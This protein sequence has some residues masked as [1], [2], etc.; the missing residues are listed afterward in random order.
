MTKSKALDVFG[1]F[2]MS[3]TVEASDTPEKWW[4]M[5]KVC[6]RLHCPMAEKCQH[7]D[8][9]KCAHE[10]KFLYSAVGMILDDIEGVGDLMSSL[11]KSIY[12]VMLVPVARQIFFYMKKDYGMTESEMFYTTRKDDIRAH[13]VS[14]ELRR[15]LTLYASLLDKFKINELWKKK[16]HQSPTVESVGGIYFDGD[17]T[18]GDPFHHQK[19]SRPQR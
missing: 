18:K 4:G 14:E 1:S 12:S 13:P 6:D 3:D 19:I 17:D 15:S 8:A 11:E 5:A 16:F 9:K 10:A 2:D 7:L